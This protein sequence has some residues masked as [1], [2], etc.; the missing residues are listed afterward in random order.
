MR[1]QYDSWSKSSHA[2][3]TTCNSC[4]APENLYMKYFN[5]AE[6]GLNHGWKFTTGKFHDPIQIRPH[7][8]DIAMKSCLKCHG[9]LMNSV[10]HQDAL[11][12]GRSCVR[13]HKNIGHTH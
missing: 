3:V 8:F 2:H 12:E 13:C 6:N 7:N 4:H 10:Q 1:E 9:D 11:L 5:K